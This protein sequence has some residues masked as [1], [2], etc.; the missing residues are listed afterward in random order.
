MQKTT[1]NRVQLMKRALYLPQQMLFH[2]T[3]M[4]KPQAKHLRGTK[5][6][7]RQMPLLF[8]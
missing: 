6:V 5:T 1:G 7:K 3:Q 4:A 2:L 8:L